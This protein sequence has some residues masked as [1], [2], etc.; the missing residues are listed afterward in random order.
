MHNPGSGHPFPSLGKAAKRG[1]DLF[2]CAMAFPVFGPVCLYI[3]WRIRSEDGGGVFFFQKRVGQGGRPFLCAK[4]R[5]MNQGRVTRIGE[6]LRSTGLDELAQV[7]NIFRGE[8]SAVG[9][10]PLTQEDIETMGCPFHCEFC[11]KDAF[12]EGGKTFYTQKVDEALAEIN[13]LPGRHLYFLDDHLLGHRRFASDLFNGMKGM[14]RVF[15]GAATVDSILEGDLIEEAMAAG[16]RSIFI[17]FESLD[18]ANLKQSSKRQNLGRNYERAIQRLHD[19]GVMINGSF[20][21]GLD[22]DDKNVFERTVNWAVD[23]GITTSTFHIATPYPGTA[24]YKKMQRAGRL[25]TDN[26]DLYD[27]RHVTFKPALLKPEELKEGYDWA[28]KE[29]YKWRFVVKSSLFHGSLKHQ[30]KHFFYTAG[31]K[32]FEPLWN[33]II[34]LKKLKLMTPL[35]EGV[36][37]KVSRQKGLEEIQESRVGAPLDLRIPES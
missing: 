28:Y 20:V 27:T 26:W 2:C 3:A 11:Y 18:P 33:M 12:F 36:L 24:F 7:I 19:L 25:T 6:W 21:F 31:W 35:L 23:M 37:S 4:F 16:L 10:R 32:K 34:Q 5:T 22:G 13:R 8:M 14:D 9:P 17:G 30:L 1:L 15:Q 29:F